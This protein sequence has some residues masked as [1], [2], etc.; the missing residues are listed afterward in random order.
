M[1]LIDYGKVAATFVDT[2]TEQAIRIYPHPQARH[3]AADY[4][5]LD[6]QNRWHAQLMGYQVMPIEELFAGNLSS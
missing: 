1:R 3:Y 2:Q 4:A 5:P 6:V